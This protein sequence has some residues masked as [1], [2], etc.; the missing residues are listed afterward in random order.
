MSPLAKEHQQPLWCSLEELSSTP[1]FEEHFHREFP[2]EASIWAQLETEQSRRDFLKLMGASFALAGIASCTK[3][4]AEKIFPFETAESERML[5]EKLFFASSSLFNGYAKGVLVESH[6]GRPTKIE[7]NALH[8]ASLGATDIFSQAEILSLYDPM[9]SKAVLH[10]GEISTWD[11]FQKEISTLS[12]EWQRSLGEGVRILSNTITSPTLANQLQLFLTQFPNAKWHS[13]DA[14]NCDSVALGAMM[15]FGE[16]LRPI[17]QFD[18]ASVVVSFDAD[19][20]GPSRAQQAY[21]RAFVERRKVRGKE[22]TNQG[23]FN[24]LYMVDSSVSLTGSFADHRIPLRPSRV[25]GLALLLAKNLGIK[26]LI[27]PPAWTRIYQS[28]IANIASDLLKNAS[29]CIVLAG[30]Q[31]NPALH[32]LTHAINDHLG[33]HGK[34]INFITPPESNAVI[35]A[36][37]LKDLTSDLARGKV[38]TLIILGANPIYATP[39]SY[40]FAKYMAKAKLKIHCGLYEDETSYLCEWHLPEAHFLEAF[41]DA[42]AFDGTMSLIQPLIAPL[43]DSRSASEFVATLRGDAQMS[44][45]KLLKNFGRGK[46]YPVRL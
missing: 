18:Q 39:E 11:A 25:F 31:Q 10:L 34:T 45:Y 17:Y 19:F 16:D 36:T 3:M 14:I 27:E 30:E 20:L 38:K 32:T 6:Q 2:R 22:I 12:K 44:S 1:G 24:R 28:E 40:S 43:Y 5:Y 29:R 4:P 41:G 42:R 33:N 23:P 9:R 7:G 26:N 37:S 35:Q 13:Y 8:P 15:A 46:V 21:A